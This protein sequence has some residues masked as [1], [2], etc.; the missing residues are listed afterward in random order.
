M[1]QPPSIG[2]NPMDQRRLIHPLCDDHVNDG[3]EEADPSFAPP[4]SRTGWIKG[5]EIALHMAS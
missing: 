3:S 2:W 1:D 4:L 5:A